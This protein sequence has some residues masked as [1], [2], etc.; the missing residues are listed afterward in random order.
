MRHTLRK[1]LITNEPSHVNASAYFYELRG[2]TR[3]A[4]FVDAQSI[5]ATVGQIRDSALARNAAKLV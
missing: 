5:G 1:N 4:S 2:R 3:T